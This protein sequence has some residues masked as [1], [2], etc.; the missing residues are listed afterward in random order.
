MND[1]GFFVPAEK[2]SRFA[3][4]YFSDGKGRLIV[5]DDP[6]KSDYL[7]K[8]GL[9]SGGGG[10][11]GTASDYMRLLLMV[12]NGGEWNGK[13]IL[14]RELA[15]QMHTNQLPKGVDWIDFGEKR[16]GVGFGLGFSV[17]VEP[18]ERLRTTTKTSSAGA[19]RPARTIGCR[20]TIG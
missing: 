4:N 10:M 6:A 7:H 15:E 9:F 17:T 13:R 18:G 5:R 16:T 8:P 3:A 12:A 19:A 14:S 11:V 1:T 20:R 2:Q